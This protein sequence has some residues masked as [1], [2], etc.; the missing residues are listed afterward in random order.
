MFNTS[1]PFWAGAAAVP[2]GPASTL[3]DFESSPH[4]FVSVSG[5]ERVARNDLENI[6]AIYGS[7]GNWAYTS[8]FNNWPPDLVTFTVDSPSTYQFTRINLLFVGRSF[9]KLYGNL[10]KVTVFD[11][12]PMSSDLLPLGPIDL[13]GAP[14]EYITHITF[15]Y[16]S[17]FPGPGAWAIDN[18]EF[19]RA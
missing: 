3:V 8:N 14:G 16:Y 18:L 15:D 4:P 6:Y 12:H 10:G 19:V 11:W 17:Y 1:P 5:G 13:G 2:L 7:L 9:I